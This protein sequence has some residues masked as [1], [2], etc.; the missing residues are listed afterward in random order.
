L[1]R[2]SERQLEALH[3]WADAAQEPA[4][5]ALLSRLAT[6]PRGPGPRR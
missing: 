4:I 6:G 1:L 3:S 5:A 2:L